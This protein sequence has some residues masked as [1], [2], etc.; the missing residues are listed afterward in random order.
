MDEIYAPLSKNFI[1]FQLP[2]AHKWCINRLPKSF[3]KTELI[4]IQ[5]LE[6]GALI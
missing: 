2:F 6:L 1:H 4:Q 3:Y 5:N